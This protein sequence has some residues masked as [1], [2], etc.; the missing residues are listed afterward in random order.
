MKPYDPNFVKLFN[1]IIYARGHGYGYVTM[2]RAAGVAV[3]APP[4]MPVGIKETR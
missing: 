4:I 3:A 2:N 1:Y